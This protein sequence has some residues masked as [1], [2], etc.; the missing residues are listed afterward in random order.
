MVKNFIYLKWFYFL[1]DS[2]FS[3]LTK[4]AKHYPM[5]GPTHMP[6]IPNLLYCISNYAPRKEITPYTS[7]ILKVPV[8]LACLF[9]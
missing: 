6:Q 3:C 4:L 2:E 8:A 9:L 7:L 1:T 5:F